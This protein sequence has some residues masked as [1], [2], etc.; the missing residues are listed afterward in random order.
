MN[1]SQSSASK[2]P[3]IGVL[4]TA[5]DAVVER[6]FARFLPRDMS[7]HVARLM[8]PVDVQPG[9]LSNMDGVIAHVPEAL[10]A[11]RV[12]EP[13]IVLFC[14]TSA[15]FYRGPRW[16]VE[17]DEQIA[18]DIGRPAISTSTALL[19]ALD[20][21]MA[22]RL[23]LVS[24]YP[25]HTNKT[26]AEFLESHG[27]T[28]VGTRAFDCTYSREIAEIQPARILSEIV[29]VHSAVPQADAVLV[30]CTGLRSLEVAEEAERRTGVPVVTSNM[31]SLWM[32]LRHFGRTGDAVFKN[33]LFGTSRAAPHV[34]KEEAATR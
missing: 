28:I 14:C 30:S 29:D 32:A 4:I 31:A 2:D 21:V 24:P 9:T 3:R 33:T 8:Q 10:R 25:D 5:S 12:V 22:K 13:D 23:L 18:R 16:N 34:H 27:F 1:H 26:E 19:K 7:F 20:T 15:S 17:L 11:L 6:D